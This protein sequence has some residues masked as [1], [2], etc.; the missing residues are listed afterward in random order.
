MNFVSDSEVIWLYLRTAESSWGQSNISLCSLQ[1]TFL[2]RWFSFRRPFFYFLLFLQSGIL[3]AQVC[4]KV[5]TLIIFYLSPVHHSLLLVVLF[6]LCTEAGFGGVYLVLV[7]NSYLQS[8]GDQRDFKRG[9]SV[10]CRNR[11]TSRRA[12]HSRA[13]PKLMRGENSNEEH[14]CR[15]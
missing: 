10:S 7:T 5:P 6:L 9:I 8:F 13:R 11:R 4:F 14:Q 1:T 2:W 12:T 15:M 3:S